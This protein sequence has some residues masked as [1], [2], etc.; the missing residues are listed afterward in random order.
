MGMD[1]NSNLMNTETRHTAALRGAINVE[2]GVEIHGGVM[3]KGAS[4]KTAH[5]LTGIQ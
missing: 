1:K 3:R 5:H 2:R 4:P